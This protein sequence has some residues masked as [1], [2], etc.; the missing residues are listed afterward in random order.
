MRK[1]VPSSSLL[2]VLAVAVPFLALAPAAVA[3]EDAA[4]AAESTVLEA[5]ALDYSTMLG[6]AHGQAPTQDVP[7]TGRQLRVLV[8]S[9]G[10]A[11]RT[12]ES[13]TD[14]E[15]RFRV[16]LGA[17][18]PGSHVEFMVGADAAAE[19]PGFYARAWEMDAGAPPSDL[20]FYRVTTDTTVL[21]ISMLNQVV[22]TLPRPGDEWQ[23]HHRQIT[24]IQNRDLDFRVFFPYVGED[25]SRSGAHIPFPVG[26]ELTSASVDNQRMPEPVL[27]TGPHGGTSFVVP[28]AIF[29]SVPGVDPG[30][31]VHL[32]G[33]APLDDGARFDYSFHPEIA[34]ERYLLNVEQGRFF[35]TQPKNTVVELYDGGANPPM[36]AQQRATQAYFA[37]NVHAHSDVRITLKEGNPRL[38][39]AIKTVAVIV[40]S[41]LGAGLLGVAFSRRNRS[42]P[43]AKRDRVATED[44]PRSRL[45]AQLARGEITSVEHRL[46]VATLAGAAASPPAPAAPAAAKPQGAA[47]DVAEELRAIENRWATAGDSE[48]FA[49]VARLAAIV[50]QLAEPGGGTG[51]PREPPENG[52]G[53]AE[54]GA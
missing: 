1:S 33:T 46:R 26:I 18:P 51:E 22:T 3:Q 5:R 45:D 54:R 30:V 21:Q 48:L 14:A 9:P 28:G 8:M 43:A 35:V 11:P 4:P 39:G 15:G 24:V 47:T 23:L 6:R 32:I 53:G 13:S 20:R 12:I 17:P 41:L 40:L 34:V 52:D 36:G 31:Q 42:K 37:Q 10:S 29:P 50:R 25:A 27:A 2:G 38:P 7:I 49:D 16:D 19:D 44:D